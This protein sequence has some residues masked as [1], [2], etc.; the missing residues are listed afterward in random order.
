MTHT[1]E[2]GTIITDSRGS[3]FIY[4]GQPEE[5]D[6]G[7]V[8]VQFGIGSG[9]MPTMI[10]NP[11]NVIPSEKL[12]TIDTKDRRIIVANDKNGRPTSWGGNWRAQAPCDIF[13]HWH[14]TKTEAL[15]HAARRIAIYDWHNAVETKTCFDC[16]ESL[17][18]NGDE[19]TN[20]VDENS[21]VDHVADLDHP[22]LDMAQMSESIASLTK[23]PIEPSVPDQTPTQE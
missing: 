3:Q 14:K 22:A 8:T 2:K 1:I 18:V 7:Q 16:G 19:T 9:Q 20:H 13:P 10:C 11:S 21:N 15:D 12:P 6:A 23:K 17:Q 5:R 4:G